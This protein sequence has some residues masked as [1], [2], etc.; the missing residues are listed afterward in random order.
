MGTLITNTCWPA[1]FAK[2]WL[3]FFAVALAVGTILGIL[4]HKPKPVAPVLVKPP[5][6]KDITLDFF[7][8]DVEGNPVNAKDAD[9]ILLSPNSGYE[10]T[11]T[12]GSKRTL[13]FTP[14]KSGP[15]EK[16]QEEVEWRSNKEHQLW[17]DHLEAQLILRA[18]ERKQRWH[19][20]FSGYRVSTERVGKSRFDYPVIFEKRKTT[21]KTP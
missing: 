8:F 10:S 7:G 13:M 6:V 14:D 4:N 17:L 15:Y 11:K 5:A 20:I 2:K 16:K 9:G 19:D 3:A 21:G 18:P 1:H 12:L